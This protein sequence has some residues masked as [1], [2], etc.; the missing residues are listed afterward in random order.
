M[1]YTLFISFY[2][3]KISMFEEHECNML[4]YNYYY[5]FIFSI[6]ATR[7]CSH[8]AYT[9]TYIAP[10]SEIER[11]A[12]TATKKNIYAFCIKVIMIIIG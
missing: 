8:L 9:N 1:Y 10:A 6:L 2:A 3:K 12:K 11:I 5:F 4:A 7:C